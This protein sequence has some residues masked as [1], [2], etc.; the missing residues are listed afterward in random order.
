MDLTDTNEYLCVNYFL[1]HESKKRQTDMFPLLRVP[2]AAIN[3]LHEQLELMQRQLQ[4]VS[5]DCLSALIL[6]R[7]L[8]VQMQR[9][10]AAP[11]EPSDEGQ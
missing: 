1:D 4:A 9:R 6:A 2:L 7:R 8:E 3:N 11:P 5:D 10:R